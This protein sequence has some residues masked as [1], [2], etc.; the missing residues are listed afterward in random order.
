MAAGNIPSFFTDFP[1]LEEDAINAV[2]DLC[3]DQQDEVRINGYAAITQLSQAAPKWIKR[4]ADVLLQ[5]LQS[6][7]P[8]EITVVKR[9]L[10][11]HLDM[12]PKVTLGVL[13]DQI[14]PES[15]EVP[16]EEA[17]TREKLRPLV[18]AFLTTDAK[19]AIVERHAKV[20]ETILVDIILAALRKLPLQDIEPV[21]KNLL[22]YLPCYQPPK[23]K[24]HAQSATRARPT[25]TL[26][27]ASLLHSILEQAGSQLRVELRPTKPATLATL[28]TV[29]PYLELAKYITLE[30]GIA[31][32]L[33]LLQFW[34][35]FLAGKGMLMKIKEDV[36]VE[37]VVQL[38]VLLDE[39]HSGQASTTASTPNVRGKD[40]GAMEVDDDWQ[41]KFDSIRTQIVDA[42]PYLLEIMLKRGASHTKMPNICAILLKSCLWRTETTNWLIPSHL[43]TA[44]E[45]L[46][47]QAQ[48]SKNQTVQ[49]LI[50][51]ITQHYQRQQQ[52]QPIS[53]VK[54]DSNWVTDHEVTDAQPSRGSMGRQLGLDQ[55]QGRTDVRDPAPPPSTHVVPA[56]GEAIALD[57]DGQRP[58]KRRKAG[59]ETESG[60]GAGRGVHNKSGSPDKPSL[61]SRIGISS[62]ETNNDRTRLFSEWSLASPQPLTSSSP[63]VAVSTNGSGGG[64]ALLHSSAVGIVKRMSK[65]N[66]K[67]NNSSGPEAGNVRRHSLPSRPQSQPQFQ[68]QSG[69]G[70]GAGAG[71]SG[72]GTRGGNASGGGGKPLSA[73]VVGF[74]IKGAANAERA[75]ETNGRSGSTSGSSTAKGGYGQGQGGQR[76]SL[77]D[78]LHLGP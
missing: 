1:D 55:G 48:L 3:E 71:G 7:E 35:R 43:M 72:V 52:K 69:A 10:L 75:V 34:V 53:P 37:V 27:G 40:V 14:M 78:R 4:N 36:R 62:S 15:A 46:R 21:I 20:A 39:A 41:P 33:D 42:A 16:E 38:A 56:S 26:A 25:P 9:A 22:I 32:P 47:D 50:R 30:M 59:A 31:D 73:P 49:N 5:L 57:G 65:V 74:S 63:S 64:N 58:L 12:D 6:D 70:A 54:R 11:T 44:V 66:N 60:A 77:L 68:S 19:R 8:N 51:A 2:Y 76:N 17:E 45:G 13:C 61:L 24:P 29:L 28:G 23:L 67:D 18:I